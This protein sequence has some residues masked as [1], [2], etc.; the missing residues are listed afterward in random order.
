MRVLAL[1]LVMT[2]LLLSIGTAT[3]CTSFPPR[4]EG[5]SAQAAIIAIGTVR[6]AT[7]DT[8]TLEIEMYLKGSQTTPGLQV[9]NYRGE[10]MAVSCAIRLTDS[11]FSD[12]TL[13]LIMLEPN[14][15]NVDAD[16]QITGSELDSVWIIDESTSLL[17]QDLRWSRSKLTSLDEAYALIADGTGQQPHLPDPRSPDAQPASQRS[18][19]RLPLFLAIGGVAV[20]GLIIWM[21]RRQRRL[22]A[23]R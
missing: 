7:A 10:M 5:Y 18:P 23:Q 12:G 17:T 13:L 20:I 19:A 9:A 21:L 1:A 11:R 15:L 14:Q 6:D 3:A 8:F 16:W 2:G 22:S 4:P